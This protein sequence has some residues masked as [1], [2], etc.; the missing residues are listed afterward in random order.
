VD[1]LKL[2][3]AQLRVFRWTELAIV[4]QSAMNALN[5]VL[6]IG[7]QIM[8]VFQ[9]HRSEMTARQRQARA[10][11]LLRLVGIAPPTSLTGRILTLLHCVTVEEVLHLFN[12]RHASA[13][14]SVDRLTPLL[15]DEAHAGDA[16]ALRVVREHGALLGDIGLAAARNVGLDGALLDRLMPTLPAAALFTTEA[17]APHKSYQGETIPG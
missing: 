15:L 4:F 11:E 6:D 16:L 10:M 2:S 9:A 13:P 14:I 8:D 7:T 1:V 12:D 17:A 3:P 5:P